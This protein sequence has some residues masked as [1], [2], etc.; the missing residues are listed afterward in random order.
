[1]GSDKKFKK[2]SKSKSSSKNKIHAKENAKDEN[3][4]LIDPQTSEAGHTDNGMT[5]PRMPGDPDYMAK[6]DIE[7]H[8]IEV[9]D[10]RLKTDYANG[11]VYSKDNKE[12]QAA[13]FKSCYVKCG[14][15]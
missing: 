7:P 4:K 11:E 5:S 8:D 6:Y 13:S 14:N 1:M 10:E 9:V 12:L 3:S 2:K 15:C